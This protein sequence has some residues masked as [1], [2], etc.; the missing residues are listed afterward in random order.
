M[1]PTHSPAGQIVRRPGGSMAAHDLP[2]DMQLTPTVVSGT[3]TVLVWGKFW[4][5]VTDDYG[6]MVPADILCWQPTWF[7]SLAVWQNHH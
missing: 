6:N 5:F 3:G 1:I 2:R 4:L 7:D